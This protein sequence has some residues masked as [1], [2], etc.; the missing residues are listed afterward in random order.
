[1]KTPVWLRK[2]EK[3]PAYGE[4]SAAPTP[5][6]LPLEFLGD[7]S[8]RLGWASLFYAVA[9]LFAYFVSNMVFWSTGSGH[10][11]SL[12]SPN[13]VVAFVCIAISILVFRLTRSSKLNPRRLLDIGLVYQVIGALG[14]SMAEFW[15]V[16]PEWSEEE[17][18]RQY[19]GLPWSCVWIVIFPLLAPSTRLKTLVAS[20]GAA[21]TGLLAMW[22]SQ[23]FGTTSPDVSWP[24]MIKYFA[25]TTYLC[26]FLSLLT[27]HV[28]HRMG[29][30]L[31]RAQ[32]IGSYLLVERL[33]AGGMGEVWL[34]SHRMLARPAAIKLIRPEVLGADEITRR[35][36]I[37]RFERE[38]QA[39]ALLRSQHTIDLYDFG[40][41]DDGSFYY[42]M[43]LLDGMNLDAL[44]RRFGPIPS[45]RAVYLLRQICHSL[46]E[47]HGKGMVHRDIKP[48]NIYSCRLGPDC[49]FVKVLD[50]GLVKTL[51]ETKSGGTQL[52]AQGLVTGTPGFM[53][54]EMAT[55]E[56]AV[57]G[58]VDIY[59][60][61][62][63]AYWLL[64]G[65]LVFEGDT[66]LATVM[67]HVQ[68][69]PTP[70]SRR[71]ELPIPESL[72]VLILSCLEKKREARPRDVMELDAHLARCQCPVVWD[73]E[74]ATAWWGLHMRPR[75]LLS[76]R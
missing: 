65:Q 43:E 47:A 35:D 11:L 26:A 62:C 13:S 16:F 23:T 12:L 34:A 59:S 8:R 54:P 72:D 63:L 17:L 21:S 22:L 31:Q 20:L 33:G 6:T 46:K 19:T 57:D 52:S 70:P 55:G 66:P 4:R 50:F 39:T 64:T 2:A 71:S 5:V 7:A 38:A 58:R 30:R 67:Q 15:G 24:F 75:E 60:L 9:F 74:K 76:G 49:D 25:F 29:K 56:V 10:V 69:R 1:M 42:V 73:N 32:Q 68:A 36:A 41:T 3:T 53:A 40:V 18:M 14:I 44:V 27:G 51:G 61:G 28:M 48:A 45:E 37:L